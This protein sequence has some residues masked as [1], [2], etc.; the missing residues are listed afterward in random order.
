MKRKYYLLILTVVIFVLLNAA[1]GPT[2]SAIQTAIANTQAAFAPTPTDMPAPS[3]TFVPTS[4]ST[5]VTSPTL[6]PMPTIVPTNTPSVSTITSLSK[7][8]KIPNHCEFWI[9]DIFF[10]RKILPPNTSGYYRYYE[11]KDANT[12]FLDITV[13]VTNLDTIIKSVEDLIS[14]S[15]IF[16]GSYNYYSTPVVVD[17]NGDFTYSSISGVQ[18]LLTKTAHYLFTVPSQ[19]ENGTKSLIIVINAS[20][21]EYH[22]QYR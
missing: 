19:V 1:C 10:S 2:E 13:N 7:T 17:G 8:M 12:T 9:E 15:V 11:A 18:P 22:Y 5:P 4:T 16:D 3:E 6:K 14:I 21:Q 20:D